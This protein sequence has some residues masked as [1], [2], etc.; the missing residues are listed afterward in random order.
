MR[1]T[2]TFDNGPE[3]AVTPRVLDTL[4]AHALPATFFVIGRNVR[5]GGRPFAERARA[6]GHVIG[7]HTLTHGLSI[8]QLQPAQEAAEAEILESQ[9]VLGDLA[10]PRRLFR[11]R[12]S[13]GGVLDELLLSRE[14]IDL[15]V[16]G[17]FTL[18]LWN[19]VPGDWLRPDD[20]VAPALDLAAQQEHSVLVVHDIETG[21]MDHLDAFI[22][23]ARAAGAEF[24][25][26]LPQ[27]CTPIVLGDVVGDLTPYF[28]P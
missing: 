23:A 15:L 26:E 18:V 20:W 6:E 2:L 14:A 3:P 16:D 24:T 22:E 4:R 10:D 11:P 1:I 9:R 28:R 25:Q 12:G 8:G 19:N 13:T 21:A 17:G 5:D 7:N 27:D